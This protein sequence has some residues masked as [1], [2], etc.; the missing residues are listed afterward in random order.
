VGL[1]SFSAGFG[2]TLHIGETTFDASDETT[3][4]GWREFG[5][6]RHR[7]NQELENLNAQFLSAEMVVNPSSEEF[8]VANGITETSDVR[9]SPSRMDDVPG[10]FTAFVLA[11]VNFTVSPMNSLKQNGAKLR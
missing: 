5:L 8:V 11:Q 9:R 7:R 10:Q 4:N 6:K 3:Q 1:G 2:S